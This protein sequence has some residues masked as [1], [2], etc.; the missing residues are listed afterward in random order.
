ML[1]F[2]ER[3]AVEFHA[4]QMLVERELDE[5]HHPAAQLANHRRGIRRHRDAVQAVL[6]GALGARPD[7]GANLLVVRPVAF[8]VARAQRLEDHFRRLVEAVARLIHVDAEGPV[9]HPRQAA[10]QPQD[11]PPV[12]QRV[13]HRHLLGHPQRIVPRQDHGGGAKMDFAGAPGQVSEHLEVVGQH[14]V[15]VEV[16]LGAPDGIEAQRLGEF[17]DTHLVAH[18]LGVGHSLMGVLEQQHVASSHIVTSSFIDS[19]FIY[20]VLRE[21][22]AP[23]A[24]NA[25]V[26]RQRRRRPPA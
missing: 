18:H 22:S 23:Q 4:G 25:A 7:L 17:R 21:K 2:A 20:R 24:T 19:L 1:M 5:E 11:E 13:E 15:G 10:A 14:R 3:L 12:G 9:L 6:E 8:H 26:P 16:M